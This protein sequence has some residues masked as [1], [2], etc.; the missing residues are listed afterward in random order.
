MVTNIVSALGAGS[1]IDTTS[2]V[3]QLVD[4]EKAPQQARLD[5]KKETLT[6][7]ISA[8]GTLKSSLSEFQ[9]ILAP[10]ADPATFSSRAVSFP[11]TS[12]ITPNALES[13]AQI[14]SYQIEVEDVAQAQSLV[15]KQTYADKKAAINES[16][17]LTFKL[18]EWTYD[19]SDNPASFAENEKQTSFSID[20]ETDDSIQDIADKI[21]KADSD[22]QATVLLVNGEYQLMI[23][24]PSG[25][26]NALEITASGG[27][28]TDFEFN[29]SNYAGVTESQQGNDAKIKLNGLT[30]YRETNEIDDVI[31]GL[32]FDINKKSPGEVFTFSITEEKD[33]A[34][35]A[36]RNFIEAYNTLY[37]TAKSLI[38]ITKDSETNVTS[39]GEL[40]N[41]GTAKNILARIRSM[42]SSS[43]TGVSDFN[44]LTNLGIRTQLDGTLE[45]VEKEFTSALTNS[46]DKFGA[47]FA[48][49]TTSS[50]SYIDVTIGSYASKTV[51]GS[52]SGTITT[53]P[54]KGSVVGL[55]VPSF[56]MDTSV[57]DYSFTVDV[58]G[59][60]S[61]TL[62][63]SGTYNTA[64]DFR[65]A[66]QS[67]INNDETIKAAGTLVDVVI[68]TGGEFKIQ[69]RE[70][71]STSKVSFTVA[72]VE[73]EA[74]TGLGTSATKT[75]GVDAAGTIGGGAAFGS[76]NVLLPKIDTDPYGL[77]FTIR[78]GAS[79]SFDFSFSRGFAGELSLLV[80]KFL[81]K[82]GVIQTRETNLNTQ[83]D[84][85]ADDQTELDRKMS[86]YE[87]RLTEQYLAM[88]RIIA[89]FQTTGDSLTGILDRL[90]FTASKN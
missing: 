57:G 12:V 72:G 10:L 23:S 31:Q 90:P 32:S 3:S 66:L 49:Q 51:A 46:Y 79:G 63:L 87:T 7:Q 11:E 64:E 19:V 38:G 81:S 76:G 40:A 48:P 61:D 5:S 55:S 75:T 59:S 65:S 70:Y 25:A 17:T 67:L 52:Y 24:A 26:K 54:T 45:I 29:A 43:V 4:V 69:S 71:G 82:T 68:E 28:L 83:V 44:A 6:A 53:A 18:G 56:P 86:L 39:K 33:T 89:S 74:A 84:D 37:E 9:S 27:G 15:V 34:E 60:T 47:L 16:G 85:I 77:N 14:G 36:I 78:E 2:L 58:N 88:E 21:N 35:Q 1:G 73:F 20:V 8:Y 41:D 30:V 80:D 42:V 13:D 22:V 50:S 62:S